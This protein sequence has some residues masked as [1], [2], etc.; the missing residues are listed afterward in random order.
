MEKTSIRSVKITPGLYL[1]EYKAS[2]AKRKK[3]EKREPVNHIWIYD[4]SGSMGGLIGLLVE[5]LIA[6]AK[7]IP[8]GDTIT[9]GYFSGE[10]QRNFILKGFRV[11]DASDYGLLEKA[12][13]ANSTTIGCT[14]FSEILQD[15]V[16]A[17][18]DLAL[19]SSKTALCFFTDGYP[20]VSCYSREIEAVKA[21]LGDLAPKITSSL[22]VGYGDYYN[23]ALMAEMA[24]RLGGSLAHSASLPSFSVSLDGFIGASGAGTRT[25]VPVKGAGAVSVFSLAEGQI[26]LHEARDGDVLVSCDGDASVCVLSSSKP[27]GASESRKAEGF[28]TQLYAA[29]LILSQKAKADLAL[30]VLGRLG[31]KRL[32]D[33]MGS[34]YTNAE[35][36]VS[37]DEVRGA[38]LDEGKRFLGGKEAGCVPKPDAFCFLDLVDLLASD[39]EAFFYPRHEAFEYKKI[40]KPSKVKEGYAPFEADKAAKAPFS[41][42]VWHES[43]LNLS[44]LARIPGKV[45]LSGAN[46]HGLLEDYPTFQYRNYTFV[47]DGV[48]NITRL[49]VTLSKKS[50]RVLEGAGVIDTSVLP[51]DAKGRPQSWHKDTVYFLMLDRLPVVSR[52]IA[53]GKTSASALCLD[54][55][56]ELKLKAV[57]KALTHYKGE[58]HPEKQVTAE[59]ASTML[60]RQ[61]AFLEGA[62]V[63]VRTGA[64]EPAVEEGEAS[65][66]YMAKEF[67]VKVKGLSSLP[68]V[69]AVAC[70]MKEGKKLTAS[71]QLVCEGVS[72]Y[73]KEDRPG[74]QWFDDAISLYKSRLH[75][76]RRRIQEAKFAVLLCR[77]WFDE[78]DSREDNRLQVDGHDFTITLVEKKV[79]Y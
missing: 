74:V 63:N 71:D 61:Q 22:L 16:Q 43:R 47:K 67:S 6:R 13:R 7:A 30:D 29:A 60:E 25:A 42:A 5:D 39:A 4:R 27:E 1:T 9:I 58:C 44:L 12:L 72:L 3:L 15:S 51:S 75:E 59:T 68:K 56:Q 37:E 48:L 35:C 49:P 2:P 11:T 55:L 14:C 33:M 77:K 21:A 54:V 70:K 69:E 8:Q 32:A 20:V 52:G 34:S 40:G 53:E 36:G 23:K 73:L 28:E 31:D 78:F 38:M 50:Y 79:N 62:G 46:E 17:A 57:L 65:D 76:V 18:G 19:F 10:G 26:T 24:E 64:Y 45:R 66:F 41:G